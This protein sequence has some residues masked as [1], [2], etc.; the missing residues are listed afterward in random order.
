MPHRGSKKSRGTHTTCSD[1]SAR[2]HD[3]AARIQEI[4]GVAL[5]ILEGGKGVSGGGQRVKIADMT[6][7]FDLSIREVRIHS[8][9][10]FQWSYRKTLKEILQKHTHKKISINVKIEG[11]RDKITRIIEAKSPYN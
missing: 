7:G 2:V 9:P 3:I 4:T 8:L 1:L 11:S 5:G 6:G 10:D